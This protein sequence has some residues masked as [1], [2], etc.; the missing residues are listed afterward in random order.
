[1]ATKGWIHVHLPGFKWV[2]LQFVYKIFLEN[3][4]YEFQSKVQKILVSARKVGTF[5]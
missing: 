2:R 5:R 3:Y 1:M 4:G